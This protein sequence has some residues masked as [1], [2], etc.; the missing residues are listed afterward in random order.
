M[1]PKLITKTSPTLPI[2]I[3]WVSAFQQFI[4]HTFR[5][6][7]TIFPWFA[8]VLYFFREV[9]ATQCPLIDDLLYKYIHYVVAVADMCRGTKKDPTLI[10]DAELSE[11]YFNKGFF[12]AEVWERQLLGYYLSRL[13][14]DASFIR[15]FTQLFDKVFCDYLPKTGSQKHYAHFRE[16]CTEYTDGSSGAVSQQ[17]SM[18]DVSA[19]RDASALASKPPQPHPY[20]IFDNSKLW[21]FPPRRYTLKGEILA[22]RFYSPSSPQYLRDKR[23]IPPERQNKMFYTNQEGLSAY[24]HIGEYAKETGVLFMFSAAVDPKARNPAS[25]RLVIE[26]ARFYG[27][28]ARNGNYSVLP[29]LLAAKHPLHLEKRQYTDLQ[30]LVDLFSFGIEVK[31]L[32]VKELEPY[33]A[34]DAADIISKVADQGKGPFGEVSEDTLVVLDW[35]TLYTGAARASIKSCFNS[36]QHINE[37]VRTGV[38][39]AKAVAALKNPPKA[40]KAIKEAPLDA[41]SQE[42]P[43]E[44]VNYHGDLVAGILT[45]KA[46]WWFGSLWFVVNY[47]LAAMEEYLYA[48]G[49]VSTTSKQRPLRPGVNKYNP[50]LPGTAINSWMFSRAALISYLK[51]VGSSALLSPNTFRVDEVGQ[52]DRELLVLSSTL[53]A[54][55]FKQKRQRERPKP[56]IQWDP[57]DDAL[58]IQHVRPGFPTRSFEDLYTS[59]LTSN[60][61]RKHVYRRLLQLRNNLIS[62]GVWDITKLPHARYDAKIGRAIKAAVESAGLNYKEE[63]FKIDATNAAMAKE[64]VKEAAAAKE[65]AKI[66]AVKEAAE[67]ASA[68]KYPLIP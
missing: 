43:F 30:N 42:V 51:L 6:D 12:P 26:C 64:A 9:L 25:L 48:T 21:K 18:L 15:H 32:L 13:S 19:G 61:T 29:Q 57:N 31:K 37:Q 16:L 47:P 7:G 50:A 4:G 67:R 2:L 63:M 54:K 10:S 3:N 65:A 60:I 49:A 68:A 8:Y 36:M 35:Y 22:A 46:V 58:L 39:I 53:T 33:L 14:E 45:L 41:E 17:C 56:G 24:L 5:V 52:L 27:N 34:L 44:G 59:L 55:F 62:Q 1:N 38:P 20:P 28:R 23:S 66:V 40:K 11:G